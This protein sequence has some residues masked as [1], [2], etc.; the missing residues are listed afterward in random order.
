MVSSDD[1]AA[2]IDKINTGYKRELA[3]YGKSFPALDVARLSSGIL[4]LDIALGGGWPF[5]RIA[6]LAG[7]YSTGKTLM[8]IKACSEVVRYDHVTKKHRDFCSESFTPGRALVCDL[9]GSFDLEWAKAN[10]FDADHHVVVRPETS[11]Q[12]VDIVK[13]AILDGV[14]DLIVV[15]SIAAMTPSKEIEDSS[16]NWQMGLSA[17]LVNKAMRAWVGGLNAASN[18]SGGGPLVLCLNQFRVKFGVMFGDPRVLPGGRQQEFAASVIVYTKASS[19]EDSKDA[20]LSEVELRGIVTK[21]K[22]GTPKMNFSYV[23]GLRDTD[24]LKKGEIA[25][26]KS[27]LDYGKKFGFIKMDGKKW[28]FNK[29]AFSTLKEI[30]ELLKANPNAYRL[31]WRSIVTASVS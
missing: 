22:V 12:A 18:V 9:E 7:E 13:V 10:G 3:H 25:N 24:A 26:V 15:D 2:W 4:E 28:F 21:N 8:A 19:Y 29:N 14:F 16:E 27:L 20:E 23:L 1:V 6:L 31:L 5:N 17:R 30:S 11:E